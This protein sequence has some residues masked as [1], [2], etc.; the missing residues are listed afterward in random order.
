LLGAVILNLLVLFLEYL[1]FNLSFS[2]D[3]PHRLIEDDYLE[4]KLVI[5]NN[6]ILPFF[7]FIISDFLACAPDEEK[8]FVAWFDYLGPKLNKILN[9]KCLCYKR[10]RYL[11]GPLRVYLFDPFNLFYLRKSFPL[12]SEFYVY[13]RTFKIEKFFTLTKGVQPWFGIETARVSGDEDEFFGTREYMMGDPIK[14]IHWWSTARKSKLIVREFQRQ[15]FYRVTIL[16]N[17]E[18]DKNFG[19]GKHTVCEYT[20]RIV[21][22]VAK[23]LIERDVSLEIIAHAGE[24]VHIPFNKGDEHLNQ[25]LKFL[26]VAEAKSKVSLKE[27][28]LE[29][30]SYIPDNSDLIVIMNEDDWQYLFLL[31]SLK[32]RNISLIPLI[33]I[34][35]TFLYP[36][37]KEK[38]ASKVKLQFS[39]ILELRGKFFAY[40]DNL[41]EVF[42]Y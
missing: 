33:I 9:Y 11:I 37:Q 14:R 7:N 28:F 38:I 30:A 41:E 6:S 36:E 24:I 34:S 3:L 40:Q 18:E 1:F 16:F 17:L 10:G 39:R 25:I 15:S 29:Y 27:F 21:A 35:E 8:K 2:R 4:I 26:A 31:F 5:R 19:S 22:S 20:V 13:P 32:A 23:Y 12:Y 42:S